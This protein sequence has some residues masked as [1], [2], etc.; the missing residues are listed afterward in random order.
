[1]RHRFG[2]RFFRDH[3]DNAASGCTPAP[4]GTPHAGHGHCHGRL[5]GAEEIPLG[6]CREGD[7]I[8]IRR[9]AGH[10]PLRRRLLEM[11]LVP[12]TKVRVVKYAPLKDPL[13]CEI[14]GYHVALRVTEALSVLVTFP[15][16]EAPL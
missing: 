1:M 10:G 13:E 9:L 2:F 4:A 11:G 6:Y 8:T 3:A 15:A 7:E 12:G 5:A 16:T 14:K